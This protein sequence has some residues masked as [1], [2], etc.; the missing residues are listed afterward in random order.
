MVGGTYNNSNNAGLWLSNA[1]NGSDND[2]NNVGSQTYKIIIKYKYTC[3]S[4]SLELAKNK[5]DLDW[6]SKKDEKK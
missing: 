4:F 2:N 3:S 1:N 5:V 6:C